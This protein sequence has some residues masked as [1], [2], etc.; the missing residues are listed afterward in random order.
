[1]ALFSK[2]VVHDDCSLKVLE[3]KGFDNVIKLPDPLFENALI[4]KGEPYENEIVRNFCASHNVLIAGSIHCDQDLDLIASIARQF[5]DTRILIV[6]HEIGE[7]NLNRIVAEMP[8]GCALYSEVSESQSIF[9]IKYLVIDFMG[10]LANLYRYSKAAYIGGGFSRFLHSIP[11]ALVYGIP[12]AFGPRTER[13]YLPD[14]VIKAGIATTI[15]SCNDICEWWQKIDSQSTNLQHISEKA[16]S[17]VRKTA[18]NSEIT[19]DYI[20]HFIHDIK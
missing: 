14:L 4:R 11:E 7:K 1:M 13:K 18:G 8:K 10:A 6:P 5:P 9:D 15:S 2:I 16:E 19:V 3:N 17:I 20:N 12:L